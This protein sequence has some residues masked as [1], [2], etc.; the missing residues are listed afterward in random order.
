MNSDQ[1]KSI[2]EVDWIA[3]QVLAKRM[4]EPGTG[5][6]GIERDEFTIVEQA[7]DEFSRSN[8]PQSIIRLR[9]LFDVIYASDTFGGD[10]LFMRLDEAAIKVA[11]ENGVMPVLAHLLGTRGHNLHRR[12]DHRAAIVSFSESVQIYRS[13]Q[14]NRFAQKNIYMQ[15]LCYRALGDRTR[16]RFILETTL[17]ELPEEDPFRAEPMHVLAW[18][19]QDEGRLIEAERLTRECIEIMKKSPDSDALVPDTLADLAEIVGL[20]GRRAE[21]E[22][23]FQSGLDILTKHEGQYERIAARIYVKYAELY[24]RERKFSKALAMLQQADLKI[25]GYGHYYDL[26][27]QIEL[28]RAWIYFNQLHWLSMLIKL[29]SSLRYRRTLGLSHTLLLQ[30]TFRRVMAFLKLNR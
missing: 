24:I 5:P 23:I 10:T 3:L 26:M 6:G 15:S 16:A 8:D 19:L 18:I 20:L 2:R 21:A 12:G 4:T 28:A 9:I 11:K 13:I 1:P 25:S 22:N 7:L 30:R 29:R 27:W 14:E 17:K